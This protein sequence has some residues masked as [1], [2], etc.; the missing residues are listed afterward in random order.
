MG[1][2]QFVLCQ[3][4]PGAFYQAARIHKPAALLGLGLRQ[5]FIHHSGDN[6]VGNADA[7]FASAQ[8][9]QLLLRQFAAGQSQGRVDAGQSHS[10]RSLDVVVEGA[11][12]IAIFVQQTEGI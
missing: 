3:I 9:E 2:R 1:V 7:R 6:Q 10:G 4:G 11:V 5:P 12:G 8:E